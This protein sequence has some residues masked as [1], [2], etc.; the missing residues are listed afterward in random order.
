M[1]TRLGGTRHITIP[2]FFKTGLSK[3]EILRFFDFPNGRH[4]HLLFSKSQNF[5][6][7]GVQRINT[8]EHVKFWQNWSIGYL[9]PWL[10]GLAISGRG[11]VK[12]WLAIRQG[13]GSSPAPAGMLSQVSA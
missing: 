1:L 8:H 7:N 3:A 2:N 6:T 9:P 10:S 4:C 13:V 11:A 12:A 5:L